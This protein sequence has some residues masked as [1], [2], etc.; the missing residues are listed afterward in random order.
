MIP[1][2]PPGRRQIWAAFQ[3]PLFLHGSLPP[4]SAHVPVAD[5][6]PISLQNLPL[7]ETTRPGWPGSEKL[8]SIR[9]HPVAPP[10][11]VP[12][13]RFTAPDASVIV[14]QT[15]GPHPA[16]CEITMVNVSDLG[17]G[18]FGSGLGVWLPWYFPAMQHNAVPAGAHADMLAI[19]TATAATVIA[20]GAAIR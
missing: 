6:L 11:S 16:A 4:V 20:S 15:S 7:N 10:R 18:Q 2:G 5:H 14:P 12:L 8:A 3:T 17:G 1:D 9:Q 13:K 19:P